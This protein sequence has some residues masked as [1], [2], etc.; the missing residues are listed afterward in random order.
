ML[1]KL[2]S[3]A[4]KVLKKE[5]ARGDICITVADDIMVK[6]LNR[7][8]RHIDKA[9]DVL[10]FEMGEDGLLGDIIISKESALR[11]AERFGV[12]LDEEMR[13]LVI[14]GALHLLGYDHKKKSDR[15][16]M[17]AKEEKYAQEIH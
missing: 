5:K 1:K 16:K 11:N 15:I 10:S 4:K 12:S 3:I 17:S 6:A 13:R 8:Y 9:T 2:N 14:H 7:V